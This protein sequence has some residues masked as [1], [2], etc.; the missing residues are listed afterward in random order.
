VS[1]REARLAAGWTPSELAR[2][3]GVSHTHIAAIEEGKS[4]PSRRIAAALVAALAPH[5]D[6]VDIPTREQGRPRK[7]AK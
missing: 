1:I 5:L 4:L 2:I 7:D 6:G 3:I